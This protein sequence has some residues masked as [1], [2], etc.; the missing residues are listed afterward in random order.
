[1]YVLLYQLLFKAGQTMLTMS[2]IYSGLSASLID[3]SVFY[4]IY[5]LAGARLYLVTTGT[6]VKITVGKVCQK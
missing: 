5:T 2:N 6:L 3:P 4:H 1:M